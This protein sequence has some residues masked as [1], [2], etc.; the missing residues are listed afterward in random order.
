MLFIHA[1]LGH[2]PRAIE[3][4]LVSLLASL[5]GA[6]FGMRLLI[7][8]G[9]GVWRGRSFLWHPAR[10]ATGDDENVCG[11]WRRIYCILELVELA[12]VSW[13]SCYSKPLIKGILLPNPTPHAR[14]LILS[15]FFCFFFFFFFFYALIYIYAHMCTNMAI[16]TTNARWSSGSKSTSGSL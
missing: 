12:A 8:G 7:H 9:S 15:F 13:T 6:Y 1:I 3:T 2:G 4:R 5:Y 10:E 16:N 11:R 14:A